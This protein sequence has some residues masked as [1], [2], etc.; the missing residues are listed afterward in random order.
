MRKW[1][2]FTFGL[3]NSRVFRHDFAVKKSILIYALVLATAVFALEWIEF[4]YI[5]KAFTTEFYVF[6][7]GISFLGL[8]IWL[9]RVLTRTRTSAPFQLNQAAL[10]SLKITK[11]EHTVLERLAHGHSNKEIADQLHVSPNT[12]KTHVSKL[13]DKLGVKQRVQA[14][15]KAKDLDL[16]P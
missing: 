7:I 16:I 2:V 14:V 12:V 13:Y 10:N 8:G 15:Q 11:R 6:L 9:G 5:T 1:I 3:V 4:Q